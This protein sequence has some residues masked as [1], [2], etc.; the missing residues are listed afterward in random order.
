M[1]GSRIAH[2]AISLP[3]DDASVYDA[4]AALLQYTNLVRAKLLRC[5]LEEYLRGGYDLNVRQPVRR[6]VNPT[7]APVP[8]GDL[9]Q[10]CAVCH[11]DMMHLPI[12]LQRCKHLFCMPCILHWGQHHRSCPLCRTPFVPPDDLQFAT[13]D[14]TRMAAPDTRRVSRFWR[15]AFA[16]RAPVVASFVAGAFRAGERVV[17]LSGTHRGFGRLQV[18]LS[19]EQVRW[20]RSIL[21]FAVGL[22]ARVLLL[23]KAQAKNLA[24]LTTA[25]RLVFVEPAAD[26]TLDR[27]V[28]ARALCSRRRLAVDIFYINDTVEMTYI[29]QI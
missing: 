3:P 23:T 27:S 2:H 22:G 20:T 29:S 10:P 16:G 11:A 14:G 28:L 7:V 19:N 4:C 8:A 25:D 18:L 21:D 9:A 17:L 15:P 26:Q 5:A 6:A 1:L 13:A 12:R 24:D